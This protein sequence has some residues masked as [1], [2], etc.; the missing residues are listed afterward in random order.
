MINNRG[1]MESLI[2]R[3]I[4]RIYKKE[5][6]KGPEYTDIKIYQNF[7]F[8]KFEDGFT[9]I[10]ETLQESEEGRKLVE[11]IRKELILGRRDLYVPMIEN[12]TNQKVVDIDFMIDFEKKSIYLFI[13]F[14]NYIYCC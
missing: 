9:L 2:K 14:S 12:Y 13:M 8:M 7:I 3:E 10:E 5:L 4:T 1:H 6:G 11:K